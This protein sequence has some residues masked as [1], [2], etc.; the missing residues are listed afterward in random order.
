MERK[1]AEYDLILGGKD[2]VEKEALRDKQ[3]LMGIDEDV[4]LKRTYNNLGQIDVFDIKELNKYF[5]HDGN[6]KYSY[7]KTLFAGGTVGGEL[8]QL[9]EKRQCTATAKK[10]VRLVYFSQ[11]VFRKFIYD[12]QKKEVY[13]KH[14]FIQ[15]VF[16]CSSITDS[17]VKQFLFMF[18]KEKYIY[19]N[20]I[21]SQN[22]PIDQIY[23]IFKGQ[24]EIT[25]K[26]AGLGNQQASIQRQ[27][28]LLSEQMLCVNEYLRG[29]AVMDTSARCLSEKV[30]VFSISVS[31]LENIF[32]Q[33]SHIRF[34]LEKKTSAQSV[35]REQHNDYCRQK[36]KQFNE[37]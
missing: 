26:K 3:R 25:C 19:G 29:V 23:I 16:F 7:E 18:K 36:M 30:V 5:D 4:I 21:Y 8:M 6:I 22:S 34:Y 28:I 31:D 17:Q 27:A 12:T 35:Y 14:N 13:K 10:T 24:V 1:K 33:R 2:N 15:R 9:Q 20:L 37:D 11:N 32:G